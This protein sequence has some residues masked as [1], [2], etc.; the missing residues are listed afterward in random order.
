[1]AKEKVT[2]KVQKKRSWWDATKTR[3]SKFRFSKPFQ[4]LWLY[5]MWL[6]GAFFLQGLGGLLT[7]QWFTPNMTAKPSM[8]VASQK[9][10]CNDWLE[11]EKKRAVAKEN[12]EDVS[13]WRFEDVKEDQMDTFFDKFSK[14]NEYDKQGKFVGK[15]GDAPKTPEAEAAKAAKAKP[16]KKAAEAAAKEVEIEAAD[17]PAIETATTDADGAEEN[18]YGYLAGVD[19]ER[20]GDAVGEIVYTKDK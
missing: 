10:N 14:K 18:E 15:E 6:S 19:P 8:W 11:W 17:E 3:L 20:D 9:S 13:T 16:A 5:K 12:G 7:L 2:V 1:M 4:K